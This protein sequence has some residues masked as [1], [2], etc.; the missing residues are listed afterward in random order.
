MKNKNE[1]LEQALSAFRAA[2]VA[3]QGDDEALKEQRKT[4]LQ[5]LMRALDSVEWEIYI[6]KATEL[7][8][9]LEEEDLQAEAEARAEQSS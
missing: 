9:Q 1:K 3:Y 5:T 6:E 8:H 7:A 2:H 4:E